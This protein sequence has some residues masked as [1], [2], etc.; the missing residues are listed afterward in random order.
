MVRRDGVAEVTC[1]PVSALATEGW[2]PS[3]RPRDDGRVG[4]V[5]LVVDLQ[6]EL[7]ARD[8]VAFLDIDLHDLA[9]FLGR[10]LHFVLVD[11]PARCEHGR[12]DAARLELLDLNLDEASFDAS[13]FAKNKQ[14]LLAADVAR[15]FFE[16]VVRQAKG[17]GLLSAEH[18]TVDGTLIEAWASLKSFR[19]KGERP[20]DRPPPDDPGNPT[21]NFHGERR[22]NATHASITDSDAL[23]ARKGRG[24]GDA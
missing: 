8:V 1:N 17:L 5:A 19:P 7:P 18:F 15:H 21:V 6:D 23:L 3:L 11:E 16:G 4:A 12:L 9:D 2:L 20:A 22:S 14:R 24:K 10:E 13:T